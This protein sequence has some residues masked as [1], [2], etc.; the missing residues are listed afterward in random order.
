MLGQTV[1]VENKPGAGGRLSAEYVSNQTP[2]GYT[3]LVGAAGAMSLA[4]AIYPDLKYHPTKTLT[5]LTMIANFPLILVEAAD[6]PS[7]N[8]KEFV[9]W[10]K[11][12]PDKA[13]YA[14]SSPAF[15][16][17]TELLKLKIRHARHHDPV[18]EQQRD[19]LKRH[20]GPDRDDDRRR[21]ADGAAGQGRQGQGARGDR[22][23]ALART[24][25]RTEHERG[26][27]SRRRHSPVERHFRADRNAGRRS[28][29]S[30]KRRWA[31]RS[32]IPAWRPSSRPWRSIPAAP[33]PKSS[34]RSSTATSSNTA[35]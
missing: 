21:P 3:L 14:S 12:H 19:D 1:V 23:G 8:V 7:K 34:S 22:R 2:D 25:R 17:T 31:R 4:A 27:L 13:N 35:M 5:P 20:A 28:S 26:R 16:V 6:N 9:E 10:M 11:Q 32:P 33:R 18:Q 30:S 15:T 24:A 29:P